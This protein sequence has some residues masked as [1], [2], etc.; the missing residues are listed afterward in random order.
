[1]IFPLIGYLLHCTILIAYFGLCK[2]ILLQS[3]IFF[4]GALPMA[5]ISYK[6]PSIQD[7][8]VPSEQKY[9]QPK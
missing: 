4:P 6:D 5:S 7:R 9:N 1:M 3:N 2:G 8:Y